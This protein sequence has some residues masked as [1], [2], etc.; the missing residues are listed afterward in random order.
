MKVYTS[1]SHPLWIDSIQLPGAGTIGMT[2]CPGKSGPSADGNWW[3]RDINVDKA[4]IEEWDATGLLSLLQDEEYESL[5]V[6]KHIYFERSIEKYCFP[7]TNDTVPYPYAFNQGWKKVRPILYRHLAPGKKLLVHCNGGVGRTGIVV[8][9]IL[10][11][12]GF[13]PEEAINMIQEARPGA[14]EVPPQA[15]FVL[16]MKKL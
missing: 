1:E 15:N 6:P 3:A 16:R 9:R 7:L 11:D 8:G 2:L 10:V 13:K 5:N 4:A 12:F 14:L